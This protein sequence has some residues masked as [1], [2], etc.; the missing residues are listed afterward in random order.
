[1]A[2][3]VQKGSLPLFFPSAPKSL[4]RESE[5]VELPDGEISSLHFHNVC[6]IGLC[7]AGNALWII[8]DGVSAM[9]PGDIIIIPPGIRHYSR[10]VSEV[11]RCRFVY[12]DP[13]LL[14]SSF[15][16]GIKKPL[17]KSAAGIVKNEELAAILRSLMK[18]DNPLESAL[19]FALYLAKQPENSSDDSKRPEGRLS[20]AINRIMLDYPQ[21]LT[22]S[23]L[24]AECGFCTSWFIKE[25]KREYSKT[26]MEF[27]TDFRIKV[28]AQLLSGGLSITEICTRTGFNSPSDLYRNFRKKHGISP[29]EY[30]KNAKKL[31]ERTSLELDLQ[32]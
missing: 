21:P 11:C 30:R 19:W 14:L 29:S 1:M 3:I 6:E 25:F 8:E 31:F 7:S 26:P 28:A 17:P 23:E 20:P 5:A 2:K 10:S 27:L 15:D 32:T 22:N 4:I 18:T 13:E 16:I 12:F 24:A 9:Q